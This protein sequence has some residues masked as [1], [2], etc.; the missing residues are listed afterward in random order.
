M[1]EPQCCCAA[2]HQTRGLALGLLDVW[3]CFETWPWVWH[4][5]FQ[6]WRSEAPHAALYGIY[7]WHWIVWACPEHEKSMMYIWRQSKKGECKIGQVWE[8]SLNLSLCRIISP[9]QSTFLFKYSIK[10][11]SIRIFAI[12]C[13]SYYSLKNLLW[14]VIFSIS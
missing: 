10:F 8:K 7:Q 13:A 1:L 14:L 3:K 6:Q 9:I 4:L 5:C 11:N 12:N 2:T